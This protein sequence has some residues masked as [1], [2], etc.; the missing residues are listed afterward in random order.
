MEASCTLKNAINSFFLYFMEERLSSY[1]I[2]NL[3]ITSD[4]FA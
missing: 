4:E 2:W 3:L 1:V